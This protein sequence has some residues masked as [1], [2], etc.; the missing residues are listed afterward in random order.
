MAELVAV[1]GLAKRYGAR[2]AVEGLTL[3]LAPGGVLGLVGGNG[4][5]KTTALRLLAGLLAP[6]AGDGT[7]LGRDLRRQARDIRA[8]VGYM[9]QRLSLYGELSVREN[10][11]FRARVYGLAAPRA[12]AD[13]AMADLELTSCARTPAGRLSGGWA[14]RLQLAACLVHSPPLLLLDEPTAGLDATARHDVWRRLAAL[15][16][17]GVGVIV[18][19]HDLAEAERCDAAAFLSDGRVIA[20]GT[21]EAVAA[22][23]SA[24]ALLLEADGARGLGAAVEALPGVIASYPQGAWL[25][26]VAAA[27]AEAPLTA[28]ARGQRGRLTRVAMRLEDAALA[29]A[30]RASRGGT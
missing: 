30:G 13:A 9:S 11:L 25:R 20:A 10:L 12:A 26:I 4:G 7:V 23:T 6:D 16:A 18:S 21:P 8:A 3:R 24:I 14:R 29:F 1:E 5:G 27:A 15:A 17:R 19:T 28:L 2:A 22:S